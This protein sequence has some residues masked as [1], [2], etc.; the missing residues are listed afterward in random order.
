MI[1]NVQE[2]A[3]LRALA[4]C[5]SEAHQEGPAQCLLAIAG[6]LG[7]AVDL[8]EGTVTLPGINDARQVCDQQSARRFHLRGRRS[9]GVDTC[10]QREALTRGPWPLRRG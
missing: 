2:V 9:S 6:A 1:L 8:E 4:Q 5:A 3:V 7:V 10:A